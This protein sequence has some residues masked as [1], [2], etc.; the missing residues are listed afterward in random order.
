MDLDDE[1]APPMLVDA[2]GKDVVEDAGLSAE[3]DDVKVT[4][5]PITVIT[6]IRSSCSH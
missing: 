5:V 4:K 1:E 6:G 2:D 3:M